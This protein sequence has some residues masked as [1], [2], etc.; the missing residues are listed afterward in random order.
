VPFTLL[1]FANSLDAER[2]KVVGT[3]K[4]IFLCGGKAANA[5]RYTSA[6]DYFLRHLKNNA[7]DLAERITLAE[8]INAWFKRDEAFQDLLDL[9]NHLVHLTDV[10]VPL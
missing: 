9:E 3:A 1:D 2:C 8:R 10:T 6:R 4:L 7:P 5:G